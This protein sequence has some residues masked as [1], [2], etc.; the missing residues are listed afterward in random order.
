MAAWRFFGAFSTVLASIAGCSG[1]D[2]ETIVLNPSDGRPV[3]AFYGMDVADVNADTYADILAV[4]HYT[5]ASGRLERRLNVFLNDPSHPGQFAPP[6]RLI[7]EADEGAAWDVI[8]ADLRLNGLP[9]I[10]ARRI[11]DRGLWI[12][13]QDPSAP[14]SYL[15]PLHHDPVGAENGWFLGAVAVGNVDADAFPDAV[16]TSEGRLVAY[17]QDSA[18]PGS[19][20]SGADIAEGSQAIAI[21][22]VT[23]DGDNDLVTFRTRP[24]D[25]GIPTARSI[26][27]HPRMSGTVTGYGDPLEIPL[28]SGGG[29]LGVADLDSDGF[30]DIVL[31]GT[32]PGTG[33]PR[34]RLQIFRQ[35]SANRFI[36]LDSIIT[37][38]DRL[39]G[40]QVIFD[41]D[42]DGDLEI[43]VSYRTAAP[44]PN[45]IEIFTRDAAGEYFSAALLDIPDD[46]AVWHPELFAL[47]VADVNADGRPDI[48]VS[49]YEI[50]VFFQSTRGFNVATRI[51]GQR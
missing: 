4:S 22:D 42:G 17:L 18:A 27:V 8:A 10:V 16:A 46:R 48:A 32:Q 5:D 41:L 33:G 24:N 34:G 44:D 49:T 28:R 13:T 20:L 39:P 15:P 35:S 51:A 6:S 38:G 1:G 9:D 47:R 43:L 12:F 50:F 23:G 45:Q 7:I 40:D 14:G 25:D 11:L 30:L 2:P 19:F 29:G 21:A 3:E 31:N 37:G 36:E 26:L